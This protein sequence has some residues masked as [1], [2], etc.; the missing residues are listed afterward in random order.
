[1]RFLAVDDEIY[2][3]DEL[4]EALCEACPDCDIAR[5][6]VHGKALSYARDN[7]VD[8][9]FLDIEMGSINGLALAKELKDLHPAMHIIF[10][11]GHT[12][13]ALGAIR[14]RATGYLIKPA[15]AFDIKRELTFLYGEPTAVHKLMRVQTFGGFEVTVGDTP[16]KFS[17]SKTKE[18][19]AYLVDRR[20]ASIT[21][22][23]ACTVLWEDAP[24]DNAQKNHFHQLIRDL[25]VTLKA[26]KAE[27]VLRKGHNSYAVDVSKIDCDSYRFIDGDLQA[28]NLYRHDYL[29]TYS[30][31]EF[32]VSQF[33]D[34][35]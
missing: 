5:F 13:Y 24:C 26:A 27:S 2:A 22:R 9:G 8:V 14:M 15:T 18:L 32:S 35:N 17:R 21:M 20:G 16:L 28:I 1:M 7:A 34:M 29:P 23:E 3:L 6:S 30:W 10:V 31:A 25:Q 11:T 4:C 33:D 12:Q 19:F